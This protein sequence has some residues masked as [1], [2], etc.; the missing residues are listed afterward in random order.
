M[1]REEGQWPQ[2]TSVNGSSV[3]SPGDLSRISATCKPPSFTNQ[4][5]THKRALSFSSESSTSSM[6][7]MPCR[8]LNVRP[9]LGD[10]VHWKGC[11]LLCLEQLY[12]VPI[13]HKHRQILRKGNKLLLL[14]R[15]Q[16]SS[17]RLMKSGT[18]FVRNLTLAEPNMP[19]HQRMSCKVRLG[20]WNLESLTILPTNTQKKRL[21]K[22][23]ASVIL[24]ASS[25]HSSQAI[26]W[27]A[28]AG[29]N[30]KPVSFMT[31]DAT[32][33]CTWSALQRMSTM[34]C[35]MDKTFLY[36]IDL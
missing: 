10:C 33:T 5:L 26:Q 1:L 12:T 16:H 36:I 22:G 31:S 30:R 9:Q 4:P 15:R 23:K 6:R 2:Q 32:E 25:P 8:K 11:C 27:P 28:R 18:D 7:L 17:V 21:G 14:R 35:E 24:M 20:K 29:Q 19:M 13:W 34:P 3:F